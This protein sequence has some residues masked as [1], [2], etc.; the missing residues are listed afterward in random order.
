MIK[1]ILIMN[2][3]GKVRLIRIY[4]ETVNLK[5]YELLGRV[6][7]LKILLYLKCNKKYHY[8]KNIFVTLLMIVLA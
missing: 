4:D 1:A 7:H 6:S 2:S 8:V 3:S 5:F